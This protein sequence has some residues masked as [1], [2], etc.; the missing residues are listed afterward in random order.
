MN[1]KLYAATIHATP[2]IRH[3]LLRGEAIKPGVVVRTPGP[4]V[5]PKHGRTSPPT[6]NQIE[7]E[8]EL[9]LPMLDAVRSVF[10]RSIESAYVMPTVEKI[11]HLRQVANEYNLLYTELYDLVVFL[12]KVEILLRQPLTVVLFWE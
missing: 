11:N 3:R 9:S 1:K 4:A 7:S 6:I 2:D 10:N 5:K 12:D 8:L